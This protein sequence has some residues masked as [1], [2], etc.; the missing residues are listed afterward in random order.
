MLYAPICFSERDAI[1]PL[2]TFKL[3]K[4]YPQPMNILHLKLLLKKCNFII[5]VTNINII[6]FF[7]SS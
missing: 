3:F 6:L 4:R 7:F 5:I 1:V 2:I